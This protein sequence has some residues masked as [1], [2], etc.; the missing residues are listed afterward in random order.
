MSSK[1]RL[2]ARYVSGELTQDE[3]LELNRLL[4]SDAQTLDDF[5]ET[6]L[7]EMQLP[8]ELSYVVSSALHPTNEDDS[9]PTSRR[10]NSRSNS[11]RAGS[12]DGRS[13]HSRLVWSGAI[14]AALIIG[15]GSFSWWSKVDTQFPS[16][17]TAKSVN[18]N[19]SQVDSGVDSGVVSS[20]PS[21]VATV[22]SIEDCVWTKGQAQLKR[23]SSISMGSR[24]SLDRGLLGVVFA[25]GARI[26]VTGPCDLVFSDSRSCLL[27]L[28]SLAASVP[29]SAVGFAVTTPSSV[30]VD[31]GTEF[32]VAVDESGTSEVHVFEGE[33]ATHPI[34]NTGL[35][36]GEIKRL[37]SREAR[38]FEIGG[39]TLRD[40]EANEAQFV[41]TSRQPLPPDE[42]P[43]LPITEQLAL[44]LAADQLVSVDENGGVA[45]WGDIL[46]GD[47]KT[48]D[49]ALQPNPTQRPLWT[50]DGLNGRPGLL[51]DGEES[52]LI[53]TPMATADE[54]TLFFVLSVAK[55]DAS[56]MQLINYNGPP[57]RH[58]VFRK[59]FA[60]TGVLHVGTDS[61][62][63][64]RPDG[65][66]FIGF[67][68]AG[69]DFKEASTAF[70][71]ARCCS[72]EVVAWDEP[73]VI[74]YC[75]SLEQGN[76]SLYLN[77][78]LQESSSAHPPIAILSRKV[79]GRHPH[80]NLKAALHGTLA[81]L[82]IY[83]G[84]LSDGGVQRVT[85]FLARRYNIALR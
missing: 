50:P 11:G 46:I 34:D 15:L 48:H 76:A 28:G 39:T 30:T 33:V 16:D 17:H 77:G 51:F 84:A 32:G 18:A 44:W 3:F 4:R 25:S 6:V 58:V 75:Y 52:F 37:T 73:V 1:E 59:G 66:G 7:I 8:E 47:N 60:E 12:F 53:T 38:L 80:E 41:R 9:P 19:R 79:I 26:T 29:S 27:R 31:L 74:A 45:A 23:G 63:F 61:R 40:I 5:V 85:K 55:S 67:V 78:R 83:N 82:L 71:S 43:E 42:L 64:N 21:T 57:E 65:L 20:Q 62:L 14:A 72:R 81:E 68:F 36:S 2:I 49:D 35:R 13:S 54:Q 10:G 70:D 22:C 56:K 24:I 69:H